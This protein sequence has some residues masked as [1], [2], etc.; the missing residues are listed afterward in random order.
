MPTTWRSRLA[1]SLALYNRLDQSFK[2]S[3]D[4]IAGVTLMRKSIEAAE[5][6]LEQMVWSYSKEKR[7]NV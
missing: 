4:A 7:W 5:A 3:I 6:L 2:M 1:S